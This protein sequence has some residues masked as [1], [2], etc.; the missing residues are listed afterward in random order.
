MCKTIKCRICGKIEF[1]DHWDKKTQRQLWW[2][3]V[4]F[5]CNHWRIQH[6]LDR[7]K[8]GKYGYAVVDGTHYTLGPTPP[9]DVRWPVGH[10]GSL[11]KFRFNDGTVRECQNVWC[12]GDLKNA[13]PYWRQV[14][15][16]NA[17]IINE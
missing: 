6:K 8:R 2:H 3:R 7:R 4:C 13:H 15:R 16:D 5:T 10:G 11:F 9:K 1:L 14:I 17:T 12:Q